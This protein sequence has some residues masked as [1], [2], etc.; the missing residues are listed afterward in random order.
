MVLAGKGIGPMGNIIGL[1][2]SIIFAIY[3]TID[4]IR[5]RRALQSI[6]RDVADLIDLANAGREG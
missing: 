5:V 1:S 2:A 6:R 4:L 3:I